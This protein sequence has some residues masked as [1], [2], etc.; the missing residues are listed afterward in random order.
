[1]MTNTT[2][3]DRYTSSNKYIVKYGASANMMRG[4]PIPSFQIACMCE[5]SVVVRAILIKEAKIDIESSG[6]GTTY[7]H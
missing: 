4:T 2:V 3:K 7:A 1:M 6:E 5:C